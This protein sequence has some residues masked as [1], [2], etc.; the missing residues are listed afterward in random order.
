MSHYIILWKFTDEGIKNLKGSPKRTETFKDIIEKAGGKLVATYYTMGLYDGVAVVEA[1]DD[2][3][4][5]STL[6]SF[7]SQ[8]GSSRTITLKAFTT[9]ETAKI[10]GSIWVVG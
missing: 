5:M 4:V 3:T 2:T 6:L 1:P 10:I 8:Q 7:E 9:E